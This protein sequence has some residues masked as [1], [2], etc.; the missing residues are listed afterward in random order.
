VAAGVERVGVGERRHDVRT[1]A[2]R[3][4]GGVGAFR[5]A[6][7]RDLAELR[8]RALHEVVELVEI[9]GPGAPC[10]RRR[11]GDE[12]VHRHE[13]PLTCIDTPCIAQ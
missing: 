4:L 5:P 8:H 9:V 7:R 3:A 12:R 6:V 2:A 1:R 13:V 10:R 11:D